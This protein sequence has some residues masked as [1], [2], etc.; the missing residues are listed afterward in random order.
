MNISKTHTRAAIL[1][2]ATV[3]TGAAIPIGA[4]AN[5]L[6][7]PQGEYLPVTAS[8]AYDAVEVHGSLS[9]TG[10]SASGTILSLNDGGTMAVGADSGDNAAVSIGDYAQLK[11][12]GGATTIGGNGGTGLITLGGRRINNAT[13][14][15]TDTAKNTASF[16]ASNIWAS[17]NATGGTIDLV[18]LNE[19]GLLLQP[20][21]GCKIVN[22]NTSC[23]ARILFNGGILAVDNAWG[24]GSQFQSV[25]GNGGL[26]ASGN[27]GKAIVLE[28]ENGHPIDLRYRW[29]SETTA[30]VLG[31]VK[32]AG[33]GSMRVWGE[34]GSANHFGWLVSAG[35]FIWGHKG[36]LELANNFC[37]V[38]GAADVLPCLADGGD[39]I[40][41]GDSPYN[42]LNLN[43]Y[44]Q[45]I[46]GLVATGR[47]MLTNG[48]ANVA[49]LTFGAARP[50][51][52]LQAPVVGGKINVR[53]TGAG[54]L[55]IT[56]TADFTKL[57]VEGGTVRFCRNA[58][59][60]NSI[61]EIELAA[62]SALVVD[63]TIVRASVRNAGASVTCLNGGRLI[64]TTS[65]DGFAI[66]PAE[67]AGGASCEWVKTGAGTLAV[68]ATNLISIPSLHVAEG[69][70]RLSAGGTAHPWLRFSFSA[71][72]PS[73]ANFCL[74][75]IKVMDASGNRVDGG[76]AWT[77]L[78]TT[79][80]FYD[81][82]VPEGSD[83][84]NAP[85]DTT[86]GTMTPQSVWASD[87][88]FS[89]NNT[90]GY[91]ERSPSCLFDG[92]A[93]TKL[94]Y[95]S[96]ATAAN[97]KVFVL[98]LP[99]GAA[100]AAGYLFRNGYSGTTHPSAWTLESSPDGVNWTTVDSKSGVV[101]PSSNTTW[102]NGGEAWPIN[103]GDV[104]GAAGFAPTAAVQVDEG[105]ALDCSLVTGGQTLSNIVVD[106]ALGGGTIR[107]AVFAANGTLSVV[108]APDANL[109]GG[110]EIP[111]D[112]DGVTGTENF[113]D[114]TLVV[115][116]VSSSKRIR[117]SNG[118]IAVGDPPTVMVFR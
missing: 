108:N 61:G 96:K 32:T 90:P 117:F 57:T 42:W 102:Y 34:T 114:W 8:A 18:R 51:G 41:T 93:Y 52:T 109:V 82:N 106:W 92:Q 19:G 118:R 103:S 84:A 85:S 115:N 12:I 83:V 38:C 73:S 25:S 17:A 91:R 37:L 78:A 36:D 99:S 66:V 3:A 56:N 10:T 4:N 43:R 97:P 110:T 1:A 16:Y 101:P 87:A 46:N 67:D 2:A 111:L 74:S 54:T 27:G 20:Q 39:V 112:F 47:S 28:S 98:R 72:N 94:Q 22:P 116:G 58:A 70:L 113:R 26:I 105:A 77:R 80:P 23:D 69:T 65:S 95:L 63:G 75:E 5:T 88:M 33:D 50:D 104:P 59:G 44:S 100:N 40:L 89:L 71:M 24:A 79:D 6:I 107:N 55:T 11:T 35:N 21:K 15:L 31:T 30:P 13:E 81:A 45:S 48:N 29:G 7:V 60:S 14:I 64:S 68:V 62:G 49:T 86:P 76:G 9:V 53:K